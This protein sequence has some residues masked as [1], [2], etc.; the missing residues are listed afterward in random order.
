MS[1][2]DARIKIETWRNDDNESRPHSGLAYLTPVVFAL[3]QGVSA[4]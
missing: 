2:E 4:D 3:K 1:L